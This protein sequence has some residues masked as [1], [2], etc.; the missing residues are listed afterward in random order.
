[1]Q[2]EHNIQLVVFGLLWQKKC[3]GEENTVK[4]EREVE[5]SKPVWRKCICYA[6]QSLL[7]LALHSTAA[8]AD[9]LHEDVTC[10]VDTGFWLKRLSILKDLQTCGETISKP[11][12]VEEPLITGMETFSVNYKV[13]WELSLVIS[14]KALTK[15]QLIFRFLFHCKHVHRQLCAAWQLHQGARARD[16]HGTAISS[17]SILCM[18]MLKFINSLLHYLIFEPAQKSRTQLR[19]LVRPAGALAKE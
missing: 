15:C 7:D 13:Q 17:S 2:E 16:M 19:R 9:P 11:D 12:V 1:M 10:L 5:N 18:N 3:F 8:A 14:R 6:L 4:I